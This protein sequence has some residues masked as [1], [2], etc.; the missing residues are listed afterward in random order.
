MLPNSKKEWLS[1]FFSKDHFSGADRVFDDREMP[2][3]FSQRSVAMLS[4]SSIQSVSQ[5]PVVRPS[6]VADAVRQ[7]SPLKAIEPT[8]AVSKERSRAENKTPEAGTSAQVAAA[9]RA[10]VPAQAA[11]V[12][13]AKPSAEGKAQQAQAPVPLNEQPPAE[14]SQV[15]KALDTQIKGLLSNVWKASAR[16]VDFLLGRDTVEQAKLA[17]EAAQK[18]QEDI[19]PIL[20]AEKNAKAAPSAASQNATG[21]P[22]V[23]YTSKGSAD[24]GKVDPRGQILDFVA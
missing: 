23:A 15:Q 12:Q 13:Q 1:C 14:K 24:S 4:L 10:A 11:A 3:A 17:S 9:A 8:T 16:A 18:L 7:S 21:S 5:A 20:K 6:L 2:C 19:W 22:V